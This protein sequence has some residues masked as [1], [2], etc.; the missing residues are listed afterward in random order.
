MH[1][2]IEVIC[3]RPNP[4]G[5]LEADVVCALGPGRILLEALAINKAALCLNVH[6]HWRALDAAPPATAGREDSARSC[7]GVAQAVT[8]ATYRAIRRVTPA[9]LC[10]ALHRLAD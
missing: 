1:E 6:R 10:R 9:N 3:N 7:A 5:L 4:F 8:L 2:R